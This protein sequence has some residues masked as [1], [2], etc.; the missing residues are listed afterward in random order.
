M[1]FRK[2]I[3]TAGSGPKRRDGIGAVRQ[4]YHKMRLS[5][6]CIC[7]GAALLV[8]CGGAAAPLS[9][10]PDARSAAVGSVRAVHGT[11]TG[12]FTVLH[13]FGGW[14]DGVRPFGGLTNVD[15]TLYGTTS[16]GGTD[17]SGTIFAVTPS[18]R[19]T[20]LHSFSRSE[21]SSPYA[22]PIAAKGILYRTASAGGKNDKGT[23]WA[24][25]LKR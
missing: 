18:G 22:P 12:Q 7:V 23:L 1:T 16:N 10:I 21:G 13:S 8:S 4:T 11:P 17:D 9:A 24:L 19:E 5:S 6:L 25:A 14:G 15:G 3:Y 20:V 2:S